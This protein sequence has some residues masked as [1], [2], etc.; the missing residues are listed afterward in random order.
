MKRIAHSHFQPHLP[1][2]AQL[3]D[4]PPRPP[5]LINE[6]RM[7]SHDRD[8]ITPPRTPQPHNRPLRPPKL[9]NHLTLRERNQRLSRKTLRMNRPNLNPLK[10]P[11]NLKQNKRILRIRKR[12]FNRLLQRRFRW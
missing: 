6:M 1:L 2:S 5:L 4:M 8:P 10:H 11:M 3:Q 7:N 12:L 9:P